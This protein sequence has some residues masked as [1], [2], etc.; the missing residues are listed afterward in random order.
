MMDTPMADITIEQALFH[1]EESTAPRL[2]ARSPG[3][4]DE[5]LPEAEWLVMGF[6]DPP[7]GVVLPAAVYAQ[8]LGKQHVAAVQVAEQGNA[9]RA[10][11]L[12]FHVLVI[13]RAAYPRFLGDPFAIARRLPPPWDTPDALPAR[14]LPAEP[15]PAR[16]VQEVQQVLKRTRGAALKEDEDPTAADAPEPTISNAQSPALLGG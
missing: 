9:G 10:A 5:W 12:G 4:R 14:T 6:G 15:L 8:P 7:A 16:T 11:A 2:R 3:F 1:K 13:P